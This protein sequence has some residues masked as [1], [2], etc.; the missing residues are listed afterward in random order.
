MGCLS[1]D[2]LLLVGGADIDPVRYGQDRGPG[3]GAVD[4]ARDTWETALLS[5]ALDADP[6]ILGVCR[7][8]QLIN[9]LLGGTLHRHLPD[10]VGHE[11][12]QPA[13][14]VFAPNVIELDETRLPGSV[15]GHMREVGGDQYFSCSLVARSGGTGEVVFTDLTGPPLL[16]ALLSIGAAPAGV[17]A[18]LDRFR[19]AHMERCRDL[20]DGFWE[21]GGQEQVHLPAPELE[22]LLRA[23]AERP[24]T[25]RALVEDEFARYFE[26]DLIGAHA[27]HLTVDAMAGVLAEAGAV[28]AEPAA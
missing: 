2:G 15:L 14:A 1:L 12:H 22:R 8:M 18:D 6:A 20:P 3:C 19:F 13:E 26:Q 7:G 23:L 16:D 5:L 10:L 17:P 9:V 24:R 27:L 11:G 4:P 21:L 28:R 25:T